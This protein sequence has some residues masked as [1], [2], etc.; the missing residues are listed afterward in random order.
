MSSMSHLVAN[1]RDPIW[2]LKQ[3]WAES[4]CRSL[5][6]LICQSVFCLPFRHLFNHHSQFDRSLGF[7]LNGRRTSTES[8]LYTRSNDCRRRWALIGPRAGFT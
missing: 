3:C 1:S 8:T 6:S 5:S 7:S 2:W 4:R